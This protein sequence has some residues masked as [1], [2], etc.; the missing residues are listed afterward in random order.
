M[1]SVQS[2]L[3]GLDA[4]GSI[5]GAITFSKWKG[6]N[7]VRIKATPSNPR[8]AGQTAQR[9]MMRF[10]SQ[11]WALMT[12]LEQAAWD[13]LSKIGNVSPFNAFVRFNL[14]RW[15]QFNFP[16]DMPTPT[17]G[18]VPVMGAMTLTGGKGIIQVDQ[19]ITTANDIWGMIVYKDGAAIVTQTKDMVA[20]VSKDI[21]GDGGT[22]TV[23]LNGLEAGTYHIR[24][25]GIDQEGEESALVADAS[26]VV[27]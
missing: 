18:T 16:F 5:G 6:R 25:S 20:Y 17:A 2:P 22:M 26:V 4:S 9:A 24:T 19:V 15:T 11:V 7:Y 3:F 13:D 21:V 10:L 1:A 14:D 12:G 27:T 23:I 8:S